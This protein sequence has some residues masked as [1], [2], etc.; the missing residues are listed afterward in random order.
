MRTFLLLI[1][2]AMAIVSII[3]MLASND[4]IWGILSIINY[5]TFLNI[6]KE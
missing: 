4:P 3:A 5:M 2:G 1:S 6:E